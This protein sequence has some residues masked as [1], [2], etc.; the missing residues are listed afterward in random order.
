MW[1]EQFL[2]SPPMCPEG[3]AEAL[4]AVQCSRA[5]GKPKRRGVSGVGVQW[6]RFPLFSLFFL[7]PCP[8]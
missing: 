7:I 4:P 6:G 5:P 3:C 2:L 8:G 1:D